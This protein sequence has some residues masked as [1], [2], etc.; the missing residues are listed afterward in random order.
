MYDM[1]LP[2]Y[3]DTLSNLKLK[4]QCVLIFV[5]YRQVERNEKFQKKLKTRPEQLLGYLLLEIAYTQLHSR[6]HTDCSNSY[7]CD[8][9]QGIL[10]NGVRLST[11]D[12]LIKVA[13]FVKKGDNIYN[14][15]RS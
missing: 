11:V 7:C 5:L 4:T 9:N 15:K 2:F 6:A 12:L 14:L 1:H 3:G 8:C 13:C 10:A